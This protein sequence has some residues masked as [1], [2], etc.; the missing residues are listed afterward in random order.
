M[1]NPSVI[2][3]SV[4]NSAGRPLFELGEAKS[5]DGSP[6]RMFLRERRGC[7]GRIGGRSSFASVRGTTCSRATITHA[8]SGTSSKDWICPSCCS[9]FNRWPAK[10]DGQPSTRRFRWRCGCTRPCAAWGVLANWPAA[11]VNGA[12]FPSRGSAAE[13]RSITTRS[14]ASA[15]NTSR[16]WTVC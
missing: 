7:G 15:R 16:F 12:K 14:P 11:V 6:L 4:T 8:L 3:G 5:P 10:L 9:K 1:K 2:S 13:F